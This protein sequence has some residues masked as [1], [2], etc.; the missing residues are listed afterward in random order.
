MKKTLSLLALLVVAGMASAPAQAATHYVSV[1]GGISWMNNMK[2]DNIYQASINNRSIDYDL[3]SGINLLGAIGCDYGNYRFEGEIGYQQNN[4]KTGVESTDG[5]VDVIGTHGS[6]PSPYA[7]KGDVS[8]LSLMANGYYDF[9]LGQKVELY[10]TTGVGVAQLSF[11]D[12]NDV[13]N[14]DPG[15]TGHET[16]LAWQVGAGLA[17]PVADNVKLDLRYRYFATT[18]VTMTGSGATYPGVTAYNTNLSSHSVLLG[19]RVDF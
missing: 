15:Y 16:A 11:H 10:A 2:L 8:V 6:P 1:M 14:P 13:I 19:L 4:L 5:I 7:M 17:A 12:E 3:G 9:D 18:D